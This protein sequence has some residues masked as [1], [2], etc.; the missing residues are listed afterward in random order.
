MHHQYLATLTPL[1]LTL[2]YLLILACLLA[3]TCL[4]TCLLACLLDVPLH[5]QLV[6]NS[7]NF[8]MQLMVE[9][10]KWELYIPSDMAYGDRGSPPKIPGGAVL[11]FQMEIL[12]ITGSDTGKVVALRCDAV[13]AEH[14]NC[15][16]KEVTFLTKIADW[17]TAKKEKEITRLVKVLGDSSQLKPHL[18]EWIQR[19]LYML[20]QLAPAG[21][22]EGEKEL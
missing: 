7:I 1:V 9:G 14:T 10:D 20:H 19:R 11:V 16:E 13:S 15:N 22:K 6:S 18:S 21:S 4:L 2:E 5:L 3:Y 12:E 8:R 17:D